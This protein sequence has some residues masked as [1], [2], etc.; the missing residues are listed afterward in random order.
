MRTKQELRTFLRFPWAVQ[1]SDPAWVPP[2]LIDQ[3]ARFKPNYPFYEHG[4]VQSWLARSPDG[5]VL[6]RISAIINR[7]HNEFQN[8]KV[9]FFGFFESANDTEVARE[10]L[11][12]AADWLHDRGM[13]SIRGPMNF[14]TNDEC[15]MLIEGFDTP[16]TIM[17]LHNPPYYND[18]MAACDFV[19]AHDFYA[20]RMH[21]GQLSDRVIQIAPKLESRLKIRIR[22]FN[23]KDFWGEVKRVE[24]IYNQAWVANWGFVPMTHD[25]LKLMAQTLKLVYDPRLIHFAETQD[26]TPV[27]FGLALPDVH[28]IFKK[29]N[30]RLLP[31]GIFKLLAGKKKIHRARV[32][33]LGVVPEY[34]QRGVDVLL[35][36]HTY[37]KGVAAGYNW[38]EF[39]WILED[40]VMMNEAARSIGADLYKKW[41][42]WEKA[43]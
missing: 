10:L 28:V 3:A 6:G 9:G 29:M 16:P 33:L 32:L 22:P 7:A 5:T 20:Y 41:R 1:G 30:G 36:Y 43:I 24:E 11:S 4:E 40:N 25:E 35:Y 14:S 17:M 31:M 19:K 13:T 18:L 8:D 27:G 26:G 12:T 39:S 21:E 2:L 23:S 38:G 37:V 15:G 42:I 34:R